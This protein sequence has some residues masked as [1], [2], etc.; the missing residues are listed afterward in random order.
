MIFENSDTPTNEQDAEL[1]HGLVSYDY[2]YRVAEELVRPHDARSESLSLTEPIAKGTHFIEVANARLAK[3]STE[4]CQ[5]LW[6]Q[7]NL[8]FSICMWDTS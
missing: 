3:H 6:T 2:A 4:S 5:P 1:Y 7:C 8:T